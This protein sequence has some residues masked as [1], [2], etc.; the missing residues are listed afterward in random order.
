M[1]K[2]EGAEDT[3]HLCTLY[4]KTVLDTA[5]LIHINKKKNNGKSYYINVPKKEERHVHAICSVL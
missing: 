2:A 1:V 4:I 5:R 3:Q